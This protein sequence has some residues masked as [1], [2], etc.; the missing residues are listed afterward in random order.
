MAQ[1]LYPLSS[2]RLAL[3]ILCGMTSGTSAVAG[4]MAEP[5]I[6]VAPTMVMPAPTASP[7]DWTGAYVGGSLGYARIDGTFNGADLFAGSPDGTAYGIHAGYNRDFGRVV[8]GGELQY[9][10]TDVQEGSSF[11]QFGSIARAKLRVGYDAGRFMPYATTGVARASISNSSFAGEDT[12]AFAGLG[13]DYRYTPS[14]SVGAEILQHR[15]DDFNGSGVELDATTM[16]LRA[17]FNF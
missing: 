12:G 9:E 11:L 8:V 15:F 14:L 17:S 4:S 7:A 10:A 16:G 13:V 6:D 2:A 3:A 1:A 5:T